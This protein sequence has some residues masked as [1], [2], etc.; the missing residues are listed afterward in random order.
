[1]S[2]TTKIRSITAE[3]KVNDVVFPVNN[4]KITNRVNNLAYVDLKIEDPDK[5]ATTSRITTKSLQEKAAEF[6]N[7]LFNTNR[8]KEEC[9][10]T[11]NIKDEATITFEGWLSKPDVSINPGFVGYNIQI[12][13]RYAALANLDYNI[14]NPKSLFSVALT[15]PNDEDGL[16]AVPEVEGNILER[17]LAIINEIEENV[18]SQDD[19]DLESVQN[20]L[21]INSTFKKYFEELVENSEDLQ[22]FG[23]DII[24]ENKIDNKR[25]NSYL[26]KSLISKKRNL[27]SVLLNDVVPNFMFKFKTDLNSSGKVEQAAVTEAQESEPEELIL[28]SKQLSWSGGGNYNLPYNG[29]I[30]YNTSKTLASSIINPNAKPILLFRY[31][32]TTDAM[33]QLYIGEAPSWLKENTLED[34]TYIKNTLEDLEEFFATTT[35]AVDEEKVRSNKEKQKRL[36]REYRF[37]KIWCKN[38]YYL[39]ALANSN[40]RIITTF[41]LD[42]EVGK[43][44]K[45]FAE[46]S[47]T[48]LFTGYCAKAEHTIDL[49]QDSAKV[50]TN[51]L[52]THVVNNGVELL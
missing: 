34:I 9:V 25:I 33:G 29:V 11:V 26:Y 19:F 21:E 42:I 45:V 27:L 4:L 49:Q 40:A 20:Q 16:G 48:A 50:T 44:Y 32:E 35:D 39:V 30:L 36:E 14:Y 8:V 13:H 5:E 12:I 23:Q 31:P 10:L 18:D 15:N 2:S 52:F 24:A 22:F 51:L 28:T 41:N 43:L 1:M 47:D 6:Q 38:M 17:M 7:I 37:L 3:L 46:G